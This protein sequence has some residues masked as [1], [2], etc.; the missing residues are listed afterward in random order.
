[1][2]WLLLALAVMLLSLAVFTVN[3][4]SLWRASK[5]L[6]RQVSATGD[7]V[8]QLTSSLALPGSGAPL[9]GPCPTCGAPPRSV[10][11]RPPAVPARDR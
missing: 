4:L 11:S 1:V 3:A 8:E 10:G 6:T 5:V 7:T 2:L 9:T